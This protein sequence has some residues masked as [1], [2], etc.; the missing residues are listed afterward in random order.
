MESDRVLLKRYFRISL[1]VVL[2]VAVLCVVLE[3]AFVLA[4]MGL[5]LVAQGSILWISVLRGNLSPDEE[6]R[7]ACSSI[8]AYLKF[9]FRK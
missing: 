3:Y 1:G 6:V 8:R 5:A 7:K 9:Q 2:F 4:L